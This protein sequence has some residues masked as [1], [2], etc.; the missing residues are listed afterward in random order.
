MRIVPSMVK[1]TPVAIVT[2]IFS[3]RKVATTIIGRTRI[4]VAVAT[5][6]AAVMVIKE[7]V[8]EVVDKDTSSSVINHKESII[9]QDRAL[10]CSNLKVRG[11]EEEQQSA[12]MQSKTCGVMKRPGIATLEQL[13]P[14]DLIIVMEER[15]RVN[16]TLE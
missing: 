5:I 2:R 12:V 9:I 4:I 1:T 15:P 3:R 11:K 6:K 14:H 16:G 13:S 8:P 10:S 7:E